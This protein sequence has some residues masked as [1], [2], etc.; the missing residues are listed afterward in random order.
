MLS[1][2]QVA[3]SLFS[4]RPSIV[5]YIATVTRDFHLAEDLFQETC[6]KAIGRAAEFESEVHLLHWTRL[7]ARNRAIDTLRRSHGRYD[8]LS[9]ETLEILAAEWPDAP[10]PDL[11]LEALERCLQKI[12]PNN[13]RLLRLRYF[14]EHSCP[15]V[16]Q[17]MQRKIESVYQALARI[18]KTLRECIS[19]QQLPEAP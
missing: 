9:V 10:A 18:H 2:E 13:R 14:E 5:G 1:P 12:T 7:T 19:A 4:R 11:T 16:A 6:V 17:R 15:E 8:G 3:A